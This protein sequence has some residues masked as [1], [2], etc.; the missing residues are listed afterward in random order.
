[1]PKS[2]SKLHIDRYLTNMSIEFA[3]S[4]DRFVAGN[5]FPVV[6]VNNASDEILVYKRGAMW[7]DNVEERPLGGAPVEVD[8]A[9]DSTTYTC[10]E[11]AI[12]HSVDDRIRAN[13]DQPIELD[14]QAVK[15]ITQQHLIRKDR[16]WVQNFYKTG[17]WSRNLAG[18]DAT[19]GTNQFLKFTQSG[20]DPISFIDSLKDTMDEA[21]GYMPN[22]IVMSPDV[23]T[24]LKNHPSL[25]SLIQY[26]QRGVITLDLMAAL[27]GVDKI[28][29]PRAIYNNAAEGLTDSFQYIVPK[30]CM[31]LAYVEK[32]VGLNM[33]TAGVTL[34]W[35]GL[36]PGF[37]QGSGAIISRFRRDEAYSD[38]FHAR[39][40]WGMELI[41]PDLG[42]FLSSCI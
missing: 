30:G 28:V 11:Y 23:Y 2:S 36:M 16:L 13:V 7:R 33:P 9:T 26:T 14:R 22:T 39:V 8:Y 34:S 32:N 41:S 27:F 38:A 21:T 19:P 35:N 12:A 4:Q 3:Q 1:M 10:K 5:I 37:A 18:V 20:A 17:V 42:I 25:I 24:K 29:T 15:L 40:A 31:L 6:G